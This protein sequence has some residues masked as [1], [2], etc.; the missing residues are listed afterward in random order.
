[1]VQTLQNFSC[2]VFRHDDM[3]LDL[4]IS[5]D[6]GTQDMDDVSYPCLALLLCYRCSVWRWPRGRPRRHHHRWDAW[7]VRRRRCAGNFRIIKRRQETALLEWR[8]LGFWWV[9]Q[10]INFCTRIC[11]AWAEVV[12]KIWLLRQVSRRFPSESFRQ[13]RTIQT[14]FEQ[15]LDSE[16]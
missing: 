6:R 4:P 10:G 8:R 16:F 5:K 15:P 3:K 14:H 2:K 12:V 13:T 9:L 1:M 7:M 11:G